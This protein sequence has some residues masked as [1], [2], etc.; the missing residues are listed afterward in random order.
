MCAV[1]SKVTVLPMPCRTYCVQME[2]ARLQS[3]SEAVSAAAQELEARA[4]ASAATSAGT[5]ASAQQAQRDAQAKV[6]YTYLPIV[7]TGLCRGP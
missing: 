6:G 4:H 5:T 7:L 2:V 1:R 3:R